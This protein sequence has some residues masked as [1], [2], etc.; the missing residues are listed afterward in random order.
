M[1]CSASRSLSG[2]LPQIYVAEQMFGLLAHENSFPDD[3][4][5]DSDKGAPEIILFLIGE[6]SLRSIDSSALPT[7][8][9][10]DRAFKFPSSTIHRQL[11]APFRQD[12]P[13]AQ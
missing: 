10:G 13:Y 9:N 2:S 3:N 11:G 1:L 4:S 6:F 5:S 7:I 12:L 8:C